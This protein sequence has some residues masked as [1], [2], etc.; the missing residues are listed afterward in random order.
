MKGFYF[1]MN[2][3]DN[4]FELWA[5]G[6]CITDCFDLHNESADVMEQLVEFADVPCYKKLSYKEVHSIVGRN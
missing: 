1:V 4:Y 3:E 6:K 5:E 2:E